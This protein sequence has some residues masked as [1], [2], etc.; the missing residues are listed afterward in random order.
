MDRI[1]RHYKVSFSWIESD[2]GKSKGGTNEG[3]EGGVDALELHQLHLRSTSAESCI[4]SLDLTFNSRLVSG[5]M[6]AELPSYVVH[7]S[8]ELGEEYD[9]GV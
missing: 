8:K 2:G 7:R 6:Y 5:V 3:R 1:H 4:F 9:Y